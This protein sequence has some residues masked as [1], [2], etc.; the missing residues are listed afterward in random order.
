MPDAVERLIAQ[1]DALQMELACLRRDDAQET[2]PLIDAARAALEA[3][4]ASI[5][6]TVRDRVHAREATRERLAT[7]LVA[8][9]ES[10]VRAR[11]MIKQVQGMVEQT[12]EARRRARLV[13][14]D[15]QAQQ[16]RLRA[17]RKG[18]GT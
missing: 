7:Q 12:R 15:G 5:A 8:A 16:E 17:P 9:R 2:G 14:E 6:A 3:S 18:Q 10:L 1:C 13:R 4:V 11:E